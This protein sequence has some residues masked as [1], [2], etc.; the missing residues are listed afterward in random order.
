MA[1]VRQSL[2]P[3]DN[4][5]KILP[6]SIFV[7]ASAEEQLDKTAQTF[8]GFSS[9]LP[10][11]ANA[12]I[13]L[14]SPGVMRGPARRFYHPELTTS[15]IYLPRS[16]KEKNRW[17][18]WFFDHDE[19]VGAV[20]EVH[21]ELPYSKAEFICPD[22][23]ILQVIQDCV[24]ETKL[25]SSLPAFDL[26]Y[27]KMGSVCI[28]MVWSNDKGYWTHLI[29]L[30][31]DYLEIKYSPYVDQEYSIE[32]IPDEELK[33]LVHSSK[34][35][36]QPLKKKLPSELL[37]RVL[38]GKNISLS[39]N[40]VCFL[41]RRSNPYDIY[42]TSIIDRLFRLLMY[43]DKLREAQITIA[44]NFIYPLK[45]FKLGDPQKGWIPDASHMRSLAQMLMQSTFDPNFSLIY[46]YGLQVE[47]HT[48]ADKILRLDSEWDKITERKMIALGV[49]KQFLEGT[50]T[51]ASANV[52]LQ[53]QLARYKA[54]RDM[55]EEY[56]IKQKFLR[57]L[58]ERNEWYQRDKRELVAK[59]R[60]KRSK[61]ENQKR[62]II[63]ELVWHKK[64]VMR[65]DQAYLSFLN[66]V[67]GQGKGPVSA[68]SLLMA[69]GMN[70]EEEL[71]NKKLE[72]ELEEKYLTFIKPPVKAFSFLD[73]VKL[74]KK[75]TTTDSS[76][77]DIPEVD[78]P[79]K[80]VF[81]KASPDE[82]TV[83][84]ASPTDFIKAEATAKDLEVDN[85]ITDE[86]WLLNLKSTVIPH[87]AR[88]KLSDFYHL[89]SSVKKASTDT[90]ADL[91]S[92][93]SMI[94]KALVDIYKLGKF[95][96]Y[97][98]TNTLPI[99]HE[100]YQNCY[101]DYSDLL[102]EDEFDRWITSVYNTYHTSK[103]LLEQKLKEIALSSYIYGQVNGYREQ[104][105]E[106]VK[107]GNC[108][109]KEGSLYTCSEL[110]RKEYNLSSLLS[111][112]GEVVLLYPCISGFEDDTLYTDT[113][114]APS[115]DKVRNLHVGKFS[116]FN[117]P[118]E[119]STQFKRILEKVGKL[120]QNK[121][122]KFE[123]VDD[124]INLEIW[125]K[126]TIEDILSKVDSKDIPEEGVALVPSTY[127]ALLEIERKKKAGTIPYFEFNDTL[128]L[129]FWIGTKPISF[130][131][132]FLHHIP[133]DYTKL[134]SMLGITGNF[135]DLSKEEIDTYVSLGYIAYNEDLGVYSIA[136]IDSRIKTSNHKLSFGSVWDKTGKHL[137]NANIDE[138]DL[139]KYYMKLYIDYPH[140][141]ERGMYEIFTK[142]SI[143]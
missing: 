112:K 126:E 17:R 70:L 40:D 16:I 28:N 86:D 92:L 99:Y 26:E 5:N 109:I 107:V 87:E 74:G 124:I 60:V 27:L 61:E 134:G 95:F 35:E 118:V 84:S 51:Y 50:S 104:G 36:D 34:P 117:I 39:T 69:M 29:V 88:I 64:L 129:P 43:E 133:L 44:D 20:L 76:S 25:F 141:L 113:H 45:V 48:V 102:M 19:L 23:S 98:Q 83:I 11:T 131:E 138:C 41:A 9:M 123:F 121:Y 1:K 37:K 2:T 128:Y 78:D 90:S 81:I 62:L 106:H 58:A 66:N 75:S 54:K 142:L 127:S 30:N 120:F 94:K 42:G 3:P 77:S 97:E 72:K 71:K 93:N 57:G 67:Y 114:L 65:D 101:T 82:S 13:F 135:L 108:L 122:S 32:I 91:N 105:V 14:N 73:R 143:V 53:T 12:G 22:R 115:F 85:I 6:Q 116:V 63:P 8:T 18:R 125:Q 68:I 46:H 119:Y 103:G 10:P 110:L 130:T 136:T 79:E 4:F 59:Y 7:S 89:C 21:A 52:G 96:S 15:A 24:D 137:K 80:D 33:R 140:F 38:T 132:A 111:P 47:F 139:I 49:S 55:F 100:Y 31:P 56:F